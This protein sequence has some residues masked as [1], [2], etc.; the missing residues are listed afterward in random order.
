MLKIKNLNI[1]K[2]ILISVI[3]LGVIIR[4]HYLSDLSFWQDEL[5]VYFH[6]TEPLSDLFYYTKN[7]A[8][9]PPL[10]FLILR[11]IFH[12]I[13]TDEFALRFFNIT[14]GFLTALLPILMKMGEKKE[15]FLFSSLLMTNL[16]MTVHSEEVLGISL[17]YFFSVVF[18]IQ[19]YKFKEKTFRER[20]LVFL[21]TTLILISYINYFVYGICLIT[22]S[23][24]IV[25]NLNSI[26]KA[27]QFLLIIASSI[28]AYIPWILNCHLFKKVLGLSSKKL[29]FW[30]PASD[31]NTRHFEQLYNHFGHWGLII[32][33]GLILILVLYRYRKDRFVLGLS[34]SVIIVISSMYLISLEA[35]N[36][37]MRR[38]LS[39]TAPLM[40]LI[41]IPF[42]RGFTKILTIPVLL[43]ISFFNLNQGYKER[44]NYWHHDIRAVIQYLGKDSSKSQV[45]FN[46]YNV[47]WFWFY[48]N[49]Y[50]NK[51]TILPEYWN[52]S[53]DVWEHK[54]KYLKKLKKNDYIYFLGRG[55]LKSE[56]LDYLKKQGTQFELKDFKDGQEVL[57]IISLQNQ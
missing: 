56:I 9:H 25:V 57:K 36:I 49:Q 47:S 14:L 32:T 19:L 39:Y 4:Y 10:I 16:A 34:L 43:I 44:N 6:A 22:L 29:N 40:L 15:S 24:L 20:D 2:I 52:W 53:C 55:C 51:W 54:I 28:L 7:H 48:T 50:L 17:S 23:T 12:I 42:F 1:D 11:P 5:I 18:F 13:G 38:Y 21:A 8:F 33:W 45:Y 27:K 30:N 31:N 26:K 35:Y 41:F 3:F 46:V 37:F